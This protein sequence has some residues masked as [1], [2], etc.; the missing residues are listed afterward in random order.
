[1]RKDNGSEIKEII[2]EAIELL[3]EDV[4]VVHIKDYKIVM[5]SKKRSYAVSKAVFYKNER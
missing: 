4:A 2:N 3:G 5:I 1:M